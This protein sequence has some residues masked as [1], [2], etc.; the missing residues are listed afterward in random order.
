MQADAPPKTILPDDPAAGHQGE[1]RDL[2]V[3]GYRALAG[4]L[5]SAEQSAY[6]HSLRAAFLQSEVHRRDEQIGIIR[7]STSWRLTGLVRAPVRLASVVRQ[8]GPAEATRRLDR[9]LRFQGGRVVRRLRRLHLLQGLGLQGRSRLRPAGAEP[10]SGSS[11][12]AIE[13]AYTAPLPRPAATVVAPRV[14]IIAELS[15]PQCAKYRVWQRQEALQRLGTPCTVVNWH[16]IVECRSAL[17]TH[18]LVI[19]YRVPAMPDVIGLIDEAR[20]LGVTSYFEVDDLIFDGPSYL[21]NRNLDKLDPQLRQEVLSG[22]ELYRTALLGCDRAIASTATL[23]EAMGRAGAT[24]VMVIENALDDETVA[25]ADASRARRAAHTRSDPRVVIGY[26]SGTKTHDAD[27]LQAAP[28]VALLMQAR[29]MVSLRIM[30]ELTLP[31]EI[32]AFGQRVERLAPSGYGIYLDRLCACDISLAPL[33]TTL[34]NDAKSN[35]KYVEASIL[36]LPSVCSPGASFRDVVTHG[37]DG[38]L[39]G[40]TAQWLDA[41]TA[42]VDD[43][44]RR[45]QVGA[46]A[47][48]H[49]L[50]RY[51]PDVVA[52]AQVAPLVRNLDRRT[53]GKLRVLAVNV[54]FWPES[55]GGSTIVAEEMARRLHRRDD[56]EMFLFASQSRAVDPPHTLLRYDD[57]SDDAAMPVIAV[58]IPHDGNDAVVSFDNPQMQA[59]FDDVLAAIEP[60]VVHFHCVQGISASIL[61]ACSNRG[62]PYVVT[63]HDAWWLCQRQFMVRGDGRYCG[64]TRIDLRVCESCIPDAIHLRQRFAMLQQR[65][66]GAARLLFPSSFHR[67]LYLAN[68]ATPGQAL[69]NRNG[70]RLPSR[71]RPPRAP[72]VLRFGYVG[73]NNVVKGIELVRHAFERLDRADYALLLV[74]STLNLGFRTMHV[75]GWKV[76]GRLSVVPAYRQETMD[77]FFEAIDVLLFPSQWKESFGLTVREALLR[78]VWVIATDG[79]G[80]VED[81]VDGVNGTIIPLDANPDRLYQ[82]VVALLDRPDRLGGYCNP[83][84]ERIVTYELQAEELHGVLLEASKARSFAP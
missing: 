81:I 44:E 79:G 8:H 31:P 59:R 57:T 39:A 4:K 51:A 26:G 37:H 78:D 84:K 82:A 14:L 83:Y 69:L 34:F 36:G 35:I 72:G 56:T 42:L 77:D 54:Y 24:D 38:Y 41:L 3:E 2:S 74:D 45:R 43:P 76:S 25:L 50:A 40:S 60:D 30:G 64:Q 7:N 9:L 58:R 65:L 67:N 20:R 52:Q 11:L 17:Q 80:T 18:A 28:A 62:V 53:R 13:A 27:F 19:F 63:V 61:Q 15:L 21:L 68:G 73:G 6:L 32:E 66:S 75:D 12:S 16:H 33:E 29:P 47:R 70:V 71:P 1:G 49:V 22:V 23:A 46:T 48:D 55:F 5:R 10:V